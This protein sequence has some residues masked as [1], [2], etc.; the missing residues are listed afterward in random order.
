M[1]SMWLGVEG[2]IGLG[3]VVGM[4]VVSVDEVELGSEEGMGLGL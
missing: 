3:C 4:D 1:N 2:G